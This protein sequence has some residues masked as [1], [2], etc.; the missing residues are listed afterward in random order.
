M[1]VKPTIAAVFMG[2]ACLGSYYGIYAIIPS[3]ALATLLAIAVAIVVYFIAMV[4]IK[5]FARDDLKMLP[6]GGRLI[7]VLEK[8]GLM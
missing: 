4:L 7:N 5:G 2:A 8:H 3:N 1:L 6:M